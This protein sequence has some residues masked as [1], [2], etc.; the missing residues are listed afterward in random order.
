MLTLEEKEFF[1]ADNCAISIA[2]RDPQRPFPEHCHTFS[3]LIIVL[4][5]HGTHIVNDVPSQLVRNQVFYVSK[6]DYHA[7][8][9]PVNLKL[10]NILFQEK[11]LSLPGH[12]HKRIP[13]PLSTNR[14]WII[15]SATA[16]RLTGV[17][18]QLRVE[19]KSGCQD[20]KLVSNLL[21]QQLVVE[22]FR[23]RVTRKPTIVKEDKTSLAIDYI[24]CNFDQNLDVDGV[25][26]F[27]GLSSR[28]LTSELK[29]ITGR[30]FKKHLNYVRTIKAAELLAYTSKH[31][32][33]V[34]F[35]VGYTDSNYFSTKFRQYHNI[36]PREYRQN[37]NN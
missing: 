37:L 22:L 10:C 18:A 9:N 14:S 12:I 23:G 24:N 28:T 27:V 31:V 26:E 17:L 8:E 3:E 11:E 30:G 19:S 7:I 6:F 33:E 25:A 15:D 2:I 35:E 34:A 20:S 5:G 13:S 1:H 16:E 21:F 4:E 32:T 36:N 29:K